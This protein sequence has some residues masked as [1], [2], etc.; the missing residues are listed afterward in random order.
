MNLFDTKEFFFV[1]SNN[2][3]APGLQTLVIEKSTTC[4][5]IQ[6]DDRLLNTTARSYKNE[7]AISGII[8]I[9][10]YQGANYLAVISHHQHVGT[11]NKAKI[12]KVTG[13]KIL[14]FTVSSPLVFDT[15]V[16][17]WSSYR[18]RLA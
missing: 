2:V 15:M 5:S 6:K 9:L 1:R 7:G 3:I 4:I 17:G 8:G 18:A 16:V 12:N 13:V 11:I 10:N 14:P